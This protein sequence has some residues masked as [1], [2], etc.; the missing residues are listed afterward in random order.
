MPK[1]SRGNSSTDSSQMKIWIKSSFYSDAGRAEIVSMTSRFPSRDRFADKAQSQ[2]NHSGPVKAFP[3]CFVS[4]C[5][6]C[7]ALLVV[8][9]DARIM[10]VFWTYKGLLGN[11]KE[12]LCFTFNSK[13]RNV[14]S[15]LWYCWNSH[16]HL[17]L[18][19]S[20]AAVK[21]AF[22][23]LKLIFRDHRQSMK[24]GLVK[25]YYSWP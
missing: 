9:L 3:R 6:G 11:E 21:R 19:C 22:T 24:D 23:Q 8:L 1:S 17:L 10:R 13:Q 4:R 7:S 15:R 18:L 25:A 12:N 20:E 2:C 16:S 14:N 5:P